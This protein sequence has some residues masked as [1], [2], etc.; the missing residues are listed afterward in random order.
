MIID[1]IQRSR[2]SI[3]FILFTLT[4]VI[5]ICAVQT[6]TGSVVP[7]IQNS[8]ITMGSNSSFNGVISYV[9]RRG[10]IVYPEVRNMKDEIVKPGSPLVTL[11]P[12]FWKQNVTSAIAAVKARKADLFTAKQQYERN[13]QLVGGKSV[14]VEQFQASKGAFFVAK[15]NLGLSNATL[16]QAQAVYN[17]CNYVLNYEGIVTKVLLTS[18]PAIGQPEVLEVSQLNPI[19]VNI[20]LGREGIYKLSTKTPVTVYPLRGNKEA[21]GIL[22]GFSV[23]TDDGVSF[24]VP[25]WPVYSGVINT[26]DGRKASVVSTMAVVMQFPE[27][28]GKA[29]LGVTKKSLKKDDKGTFVWK[30]KGIKNLQ[31][32]KGMDKI[33]PIEKVYVEVGEY[34]QNILGFLNKVSLKDDSELQLYDML[35]VGNTPKD[36]KDGDLICYVEQRY[37]F[38][39]GDQVKVEIGN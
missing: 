8:K 1:K 10:S 32:G 31:P 11:E 28:N 19:F 13:K 21:T 29:Y 24:Q 22:N 18:G 12:S 36:L 4:A 5:N 16:I 17:A 27:I 7:I 34:Y 37:M 33:F 3:L 2:K 39:P 14:S 30:A 26:K 23:L 15:T 6:Y 20:K 25:N 38:M 35:L 9:A